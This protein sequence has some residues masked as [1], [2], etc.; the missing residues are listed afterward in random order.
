MK[1]L[2]I[3]KADLDKDNFY[4]GKEDFSEYSKKYDGNIEI[5]A[6]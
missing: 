1:T 6:N 5:E 4:I 3:T 2:K